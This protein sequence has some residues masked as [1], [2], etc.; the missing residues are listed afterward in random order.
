MTKVFT[1]RYYKS[2]AIT[3]CICWFKL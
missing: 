1:E 2:D 3:V